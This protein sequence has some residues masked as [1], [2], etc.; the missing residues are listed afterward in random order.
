MYYKYYAVIHIM[1]FSNANTPVL[2]CVCKRYKVRRYNMYLNL[3]RAK[4]LIC[5]SK[6]TLQCICICISK[7]QEK[8]KRAEKRAFFEK[9]RNPEHICHKLY[10]RWILC[11]SQHTKNT[12]NCLLDNK[13]RA[14][15][16]LS[17]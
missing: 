11:D 1:T 12:R 13:K 2:I 4:I 8:R 7:C 14:K 3:S 15:K 10:R 5:V 16:A 9:K 6:F 17:F